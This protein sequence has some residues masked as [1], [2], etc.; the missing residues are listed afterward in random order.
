MAWV[1]APNP[2]DCEGE[3][4]SL[5]AANADPVTGRVDE[6]LRVH[7]LDPEGLAAHLAVYR[8]AM[9]GTPGLRKVD[10]ELVAFVV[11]RLN[12]CGY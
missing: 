5:L 7:G 4:A 6:I 9:R 2:E 8:S 11:S 12:G 10:R 1:P 3:L